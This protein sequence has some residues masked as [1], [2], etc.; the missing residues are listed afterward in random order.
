MA[1]AR[2]DIPSGH[3][4]D[5]RTFVRHVWAYH[6]DAGK[7][8]L[9]P[10]WMHTAHFSAGDEWCVAGAALADMIRYDD[11]CGRKRVVGERIVSRRKGSRFEVKFADLE[12]L[13]AFLLHLAGYAANDF[14]ARQLGEFLVWTFGFRWV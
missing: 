10:P 1:Q 9:S 4:P 7:P 3:I 2:I 8:V 5:Y 12:A 6:D 13:H 14:H 11:Q